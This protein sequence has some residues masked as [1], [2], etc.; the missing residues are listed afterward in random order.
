MRASP[1]P[2]I[3]PPLPGGQPEYY[4]WHKLFLT[5]G[6]LYVAV[7]DLADDSSPTAREDALLQ[8]LD[9]LH[10]SVPGAVVVV[11]GTKADLL[12][13]AEEADARLEALK[14][15]A[16]VWLERRTQAAVAMAASAKS[17]DDD[18]PPLIFRYLKASADAVNGFGIDE[19]MVALNEAARAKFPHRLFPRFEAEVPMIWQRA[20]GLLE[21]MKR[22]SDTAAAFFK[23]G[24]GRGEGEG[25][26]AEEE[27][28][29]AFEGDGDTSLLY[30]VAQQ[31]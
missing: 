21:A 1:A 25:G 24:V 15:A 5:Q 11:V 13:T 27:V 10:A 6:A 19:V 16:D 28:K 31:L 23:P 17:A 20:R 12:A 26:G 29:G 8:Q 30:R 4:P 9:I 3:I 2:I 14:A 18:K 22:G 7:V